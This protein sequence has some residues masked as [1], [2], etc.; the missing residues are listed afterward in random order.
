[1]WPIVSI[2]VARLNDRSQGVKPTLVLRC[3]RRKCALNGLLAIANMH[4]AARFAQ[5]LGRMSDSSTHAGI[6]DSDPLI[7]LTALIVGRADS[8]GG[9]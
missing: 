6:N 1:M 9:R 5:Y 3:D 7:A 4:F 2:V 8:T